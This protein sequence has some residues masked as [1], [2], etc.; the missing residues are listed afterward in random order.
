MR[1]EKKTRVTLPIRATPPSPR[2]P[3][4]LP[5]EMAADDYDEA[6]Y[7]YLEARRVLLDDPARREVALNEMLVLHELKV[8]LDANL[9]VALAAQPRAAPPGS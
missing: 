1:R 8:L 2:F 3:N 6:E 9:E 4:G 7:A 5:Q